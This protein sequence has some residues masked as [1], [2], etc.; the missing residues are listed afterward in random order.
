MIFPT[1]PLVHLIAF[2]PQ[3]QQA[4]IFCVHKNRSTI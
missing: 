4:C 3:A 2:V 1:M